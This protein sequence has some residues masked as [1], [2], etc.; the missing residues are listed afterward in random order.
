MS[1]WADSDNDYMIG[2]MA[3]SEPRASVYGARYIVSFIVWAAV[4]PVIAWEHHN[5]GFEMLFYILAASALVILFAVLMLP[6][7]LPESQP[8]PS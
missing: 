7:H 2:K 6:Q 5:W 8:S 3:K 4:V 1:F